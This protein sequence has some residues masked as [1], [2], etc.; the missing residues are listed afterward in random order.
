[1]VEVLLEIRGGLPRSLDKNL[2]NISTGAQ[3]AKIYVVSKS[4]DEKARLRSTIC[5]K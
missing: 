5:H 4:Q 1:M 3:A 2:A